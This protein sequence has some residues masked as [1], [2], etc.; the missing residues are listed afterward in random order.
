MWNERARLYVTLQPQFSEF[1][2]LLNSHLVCS[3][4]DLLPESNILLMGSSTCIQLSTVIHYWILVCNSKL[5][6]SGPNVFSPLKIAFRPMS[7]IYYIVQNILYYTV[8]SLLVTVICDSIIKL[9]YHRL[10][11]QLQN[12]VPWEWAYVPSQFPDFSVLSNT[13]ILLEWQ[14][15]VV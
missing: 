2:L 4:F 3:H 9:C 1:Q 11:T 15:I 8:S 7:K 6:C 14:Y 13:S 5:F 10:H 12:Q